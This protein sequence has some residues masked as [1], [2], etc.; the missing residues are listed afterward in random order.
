MMMMMMIMIMTIIMK[1]LIIDGKWNIM[2]MVSIK[3]QLILI[4]PQNRKIRFIQIEI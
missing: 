2:M 4:Y 3:S 1:T